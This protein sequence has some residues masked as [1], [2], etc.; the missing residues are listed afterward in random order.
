MNRLAAIRNPF[1]A[2][3]VNDAW[4]EPEV[5]VPS[6]HHEAFRTCLAALARVRAGEPDSV[7]LTGPAGSGKTHVLARLQRHLVH[8]AA[9][10]ADGAVH[11]VFVSAKLQTS[12]RSLWQFVRRRFAT[13]L[14][15]EQEGVTQLA[16]LFAHQ[17]AG[18]RQEPARRWVRG[19]RV[20]PSA[21]DISEL[22][23]DVA[24]PLGLG[25][26][27]GIVL[28]HLLHRRNVATARAWLCGESLH[29]H[30]L[31]ALGVA[32][33]EPEDREDDARQIVTALCR[34]ASGSLPVVFCFDQLEALQT[35]RG[36]RD[37]LFRFGRVAAELAEA[38]T[39]VL[40]ISSI[41]S[42]LL[43]D[44]DAAVRQS[45]RDRAF[46]RRATLHTLT[47]DQIDALVRSRLDSVAELRALR[48][49]PGA[50][51]DTPF[52]PAAMDRLRA[53]SPAVPRRVFTLA[54]EELARLQELAP[55]RSDVPEFLAT[56]LATRLEEAARDL[57]PGD[58]R[59]TLVHGLPMLWDL[60]RRALRPAE[61]DLDLM[62]DGPDPLA[63]AV[64]NETNMTSLAGR[65]RRLAAAAG[66][67]LRI[68][69]DARLPI[70]RGAKRTLEYLRALEQ[71]GDR[72]VSPSLEALAALEALRTLLSDARAGDLA[73]E[74]E[75]I[76]ERT[77]CDWLAAHLPRPLAEL[78]DEIAEAP[79][80]APDADEV[81][82]R[83]LHDVLAGRPI[84]LLDDVAAELR[85]DAARLRALAAA[86]P[87]R[88][89]LL[90]GP[91]A[92]L[93]LRTGVE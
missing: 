10:A 87:E 26:G 81:T 57:T 89:G 65:L 55:R 44:L 71:R 92:V 52:S 21:E 76:G 54:G 46:R 85:V 83:A 63:I 56:S 73:L 78:V 3:I 28:G 33:V 29:E 9:E 80:A 13:D 16:R 72:V 60:S 11:C 23:D 31:S 15:R 53:A 82:L 42:A 84:T 8:T 2:N 32:P 35:T 43:D 38:D 62:S 88:V 69:R 40:I 22:V 24:Q 5:D 18:A 61:G 59:D 49:E 93:F 67:P 39:N 45:D 90:H 58:S 17:I 68:V 51:A 47:P 77:V 48:A 91:P 74:G 50:S 6:I 41:Q 14:L 4:R 34:L 64:C 27:L 86:S 79:A 1:G 37:S 20:L 30:D 7:L 70:S 75:A 66:A 19:M 12:A 25:R 36:D